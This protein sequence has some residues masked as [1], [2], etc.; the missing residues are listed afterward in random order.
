MEQLNKSRIANRR[1]YRAT[2]AISDPARG[3]VW[4]LNE[5][6]S[7]EWSTENIQADKSLR[8]FLVKGEM[9]VQELGTFK[10]NGAAAGIRLNKNIDSGD[11]YRVV[12][13][14]LFPANKYYNAKVATPN[15]SIRRPPRPTKTPVA[16]ADTS[17]VKVELMAIDADSAN[18]ARKSFEGRKISYVRELTVDAADIRISIWDHGRQDQDIV[19]IYLN[20]Q[21][22]V[23]EHSLTYRK[24]HFDIHLDPTQKND[25]FL[26]A[27]NLGFYP[28]NTVSIEVI[29]N[30][31]SE[32]IVLNSDLK[33]CEAVLINVKQ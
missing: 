11:D 32:N 31:T 12:G 9:V 16:K 2:I 6:G 22:V 28:P 21:P 17:P 23:A 26:Y 30:S 10:N 33:S 25:L 3:T 15:F 8:F 1:K 24:K 14:E 4:Q 5:P 18:L 29:D 27:H 13:I 19:S 20:G 7:V